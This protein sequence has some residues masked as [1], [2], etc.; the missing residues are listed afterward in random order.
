[1]LI[2]Y[3]NTILKYFNVADTTCCLISSYAYILIAYFGVNS[4][5]ND[6]FHVTVAFELLFTISIMLKFITTY[7]EEGD[8]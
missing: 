3:D 4:D 7:V 8:T 6:S 5:H 1:M 2:S